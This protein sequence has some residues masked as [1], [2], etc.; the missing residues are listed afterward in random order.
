MFYRILK[1][2]VNIFFFGN[3]YIALCAVAIAWSTYY[4]LGIPIRV[5]SLTTFLFFATLFQYTLHR[6]ITFRKRKESDNEVIMWTSPNQFLLLMLGI[7]S[8]GMAA[9]VAFHLQRATILA[10]LPLGFMS[11]LYELPLFKYKDVPIRLRD[12]WIFKIILVTVVWTSIGVVLPF[13]QFDISLFSTSFI[14]LFI[15]KAGLV[16]MSALAFDIRDMEYDRKDNVNTIPVRYGLMRVRKIMIITTVITIIMGIT[17][18]LFFSPFSM[19]LILAAELAP[20]LSYYIIT[21]SY[22]YP[23]DLVYIIAVDGILAIDFVLIAILHL[24]F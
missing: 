17:H 9:N 21:I 11:V 14:L 4:R 19:P 22:R 16:F 10:L 24:I 3:I 15:Q 20:L 1:H 23:L 13:L 5:D 18:A 2:I 12:M 6:F 8:A 7:I